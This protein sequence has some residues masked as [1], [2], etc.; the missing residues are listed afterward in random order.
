MPSVSFPGFN[1]IVPGSQQPEWDETVVSRGLQQGLGIL[2]SGGICLF[3]GGVRWHSGVAR[4]VINCS[5]ILLGALLGG[6]VCVLSC[7]GV[8]VTCVVL[9]GVALEPPFGGDG[10]CDVA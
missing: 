9:F 5:P 4:L 10:S 7:D 6:G 8:Q 2:V 1:P 3:A